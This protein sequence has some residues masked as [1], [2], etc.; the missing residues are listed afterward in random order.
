MY[1]YICIYAYIYIICM[2]IYIQY[3]CIH[4]YIYVYT[5]INIVSVSH[6]TSR[7][8][9]S[10]EL[11]FAPRRPGRNEAFWRRFVRIWVSIQTINIRT[12]HLALTFT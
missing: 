8:L 7:K 1:I 5:Y 6:K 10:S 4:L 9:S 3:I 12:V 2:H 11:K